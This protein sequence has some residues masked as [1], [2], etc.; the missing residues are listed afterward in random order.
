MSHKLYFLEAVA[1][2]TIGLVLSVSRKIVIGAEFAKTMDWNKINDAKLLT[3]N[4]KYY[5]LCT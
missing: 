3:G 4:C 5:L 2:L 1:E